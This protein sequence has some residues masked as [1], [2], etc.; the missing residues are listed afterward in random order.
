MDKRAAAMREAAMNA[1]ME[2]FGGHTM[3]II[4]GPSYATA[5]ADAERARVVAWAKTIGHEQVMA[6]VAIGAWLSAAL[7]DPAVCEAMKADIRRWFS[8]GQP[9]AETFVQG[10][11]AGEHWRDA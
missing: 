9:F 11:E 2:T 10:V 8:S 3:P 5:G 4:T 6:S 7:D 1:P